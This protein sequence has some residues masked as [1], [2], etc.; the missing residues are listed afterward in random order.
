M[1]TR[2]WRRSQ[3]VGTRSSA[4]SLVHVWRGS[5]AAT[6]TDIRWDTKDVVKVGGA[7][8]TI[9]AMEEDNADV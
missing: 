8:E 3:R 6:W 5:T 9:D 1:A 7:T 4:A 2:Y